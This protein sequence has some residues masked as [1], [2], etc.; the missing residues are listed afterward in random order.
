[1]YGVL[2]YDDILRI[3]SADFS[4]AHDPYRRELFGITSNPTSVRM[5]GLLFSRPESKLAKEEIIPG[6]SYFHIR[7]GQH[8][9]F[10]CAGYGAYG[11]QDKNEIVS[12][13]KDGKLGYVFIPS[14]FNEIRKKVESQ[15]GWRYSGESDL[16]LAN[17]RYSRGGGVVLEL[18]KSIKCYLDEFKKIGAIDSV[19]EFFERIFR[20]AE[21]AKEDDPT[22]GFS[23]SMGVATG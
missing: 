9:H 1:M 12:V 7:S 5:V 6:I 19:N 15:C 13:E 20:Y 23:D 18:D 14:R 10:F 21:T 4:K 22:W 11:G 2:S 8:I 16:I 17:A 3:L